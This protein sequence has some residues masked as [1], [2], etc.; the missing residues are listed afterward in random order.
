MLDLLEHANVALA[1]AQPSIAKAIERSKG[2]IALH[3]VILDPRYPYDPN[4]QIPILKQT[5]YGEPDTGKWP[6]DFA[7]I[8]RSKARVCW[9]TGM[10]S[11]LVGESAPYLY[12]DGDTKFPG[13][14]VCDGLI[15]AASG[16]DW[17][18]DEACAHVVSAFFRAQVRM[19]RDQA[20]E[21][22]ECLFFSD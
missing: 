20:M 16:L 14:V 2:R 17:Q 11:R 6:R 3:V 12:E 22:T 4:A 15:V 21:N 7:A 10:S 5:T 18:L 19:A 13:G 9:R 8:A 1:L